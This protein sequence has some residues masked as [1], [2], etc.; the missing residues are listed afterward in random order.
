[1]WYN[2]TVQRSIKIKPI[3]ITSDFYAEYSEDS[4]E[5]DPKFKIGDRVKIV[6]YK[7]KFA[8][9]DTANWS[10]QLVKLLKLVK[11]TQCYKF[12]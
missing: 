9:G 3:Y 7:K 5:K 4:N 6:K 11:L 2:N 10:K 1:M 8:K 12:L